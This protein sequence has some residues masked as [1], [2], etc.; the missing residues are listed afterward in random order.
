MMSERA[1]ATADPARRQARRLGFW[2]AV[3]MVVVGVVGLSVAV[4]TPPRSGPY[5]RSDCVTY[6][7]TDVAAFVPRDYLWL[8][9]GLLLVLLFVALAAC[10][11]GYATSD[12]KVFSQTGQLLQ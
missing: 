12:K 5:C 2:V 1:W 9:P 4:T 8:Y 10:I 3:S 11:H 7:Y 6:P